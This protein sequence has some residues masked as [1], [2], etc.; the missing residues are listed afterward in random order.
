V[1]LISNVVCAVACKLLSARILNLK[2]GRRR[3]EA[4]LY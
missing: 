1:N 4:K 3:R 2:F